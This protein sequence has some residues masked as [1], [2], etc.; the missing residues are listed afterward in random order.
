MKYVA[1]KN[2]M[3]QREVIKLE[4]DQKKSSK[5]STMSESSK[6]ALMKLFLSIIK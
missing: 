6:V 4:S 1:E 2:D 3:I 5:S